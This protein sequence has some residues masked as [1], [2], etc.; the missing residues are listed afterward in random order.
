MIPEQFQT[1]S[2][3]EDLVLRVWEVD[4][5][6]VLKQTIAFLKASPV[7]RRLELHLPRVAEETA[8]ELPRRLPFQKLFKSNCLKEVKMFNFQGAP[9]QLQLGTY[10][11]RNATGLENMT[12]IRRGQLYE[13]DGKWTKDCRFMPEV[14]RKHVRKRLLGDVPSGTKL[15]VL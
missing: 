4:P 14:T 11:L 7:L 12:V 13:G 10:F 8:S 5:E 3:L 6:F 1:F 15:I 2:E 9:I